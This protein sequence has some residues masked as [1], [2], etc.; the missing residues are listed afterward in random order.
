MSDD[1]DASTLPAEAQEEYKISNFFKRL[2]PWSAQKNVSF[3]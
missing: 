2:V 3:V 1:M